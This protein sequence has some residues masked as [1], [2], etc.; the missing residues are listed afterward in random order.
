[1]R[2]LKTR[3]PLYRLRF[4][5]S[6]RELHKIQTPPGFP[7]QSHAMRLPIIRRKSSVKGFGR[8]MLAPAIVEFGGL[9][10]GSSKNSELLF[11]NHL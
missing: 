4:T 1:M 11:C 7:N 10:P 5:A 8:R 9:D 3:I 6:G 2:E